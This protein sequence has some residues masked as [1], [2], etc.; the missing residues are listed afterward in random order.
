M[1]FTDMQIKE[2]LQILRSTDSPLVYDVGYNVSLIVSAASLENFSVECDA[3]NW[4]ENQNT[5]AGEEVAIQDQTNKRFV[6]LRLWSDIHGNKVNI[7]KKG[8]SQAILNLVV[9]RPGITEVCI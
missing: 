9:K 4:S 3:F 7:V 5:T 1:H 8:C 2:A 6:R